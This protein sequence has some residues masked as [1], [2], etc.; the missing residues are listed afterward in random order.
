MDIIKAFNELVGD[1]IDDVDLNGEFMPV[2]ARNIL[3]PPVIV[4]ENGNKHEMSG[5]QLVT[6]TGEK[7][8]LPALKVTM[9][10]DL[11]PVIRDAAIDDLLALATM[12]D[13]KA[14]QMA[15]GELDAK[16]I[17]AQK[18][19]KPYLDRNEMPPA[20]ILQ[21]F[22]ARYF[23]V[24]D[25]VRANKKSKQKVA[26]S[27]ATIRQISTAARAYIGITAYSILSYWT[28][29]FL[30]SY[31]TLRAKNLPTREVLDG[32][33]DTVKALRARMV[34]TADGA[35]QYIVEP[36]ADEERLFLYGR[37]CPT[38]GVYPLLNRLHK[39]NAVEHA[40]TIDYLNW[41]ATA[42]VKPLYLCKTPK[43]TARHLI[44]ILSRGDDEGKSGEE[45]NG[46]KTDGTAKKSHRK[47]YSLDGEYEARQVPMSIELAVVNNIISNGK[48]GNKFNTTA[49]SLA[50]D[51]NSI[52]N[53]HK[54]IAT[55]SENEI[56][57]NQYIFSIENKNGTI[58]YVRV[59]NLKFLLRSGKAY[60]LFDFFLHEAL[61]QGIIAQCTNKTYECSKREVVIPFIN[62]INAGLANSNEEIFSCIQKAEHIL[63]NLDLFRETKNGDKV[64]DAYWDS[65][66]QALHYDG[67]NHRVTVTFG[68]LYI[69]YSMPVPTGYFKLTN[70]ARIVVY[71]VMRYLRTLLAHK[72]AIAPIKAETLAKY[73]KLP[74][75]A[76]NFKRDVIKPFRDIIDEINSFGK[77][78]QGLSLSQPTAT[79]KAEFLRERITPKL[80][81]TLLEMLDNVRNRR[82]Y[83]I[84]K[85]EKTQQKAKTMA[86]AAAYS[87]EKKTKKKT[88]KKAQNKKM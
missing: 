35:K 77:E 7:I 16:L 19:V 80:E 29:F 26:L 18:K 83:H 67:V 45:A 55:K 42:A 22:N 70:K 21:E 62:F 32:L 27:T 25:I 2:L 12:Q 59:S 51:L 40:Q 28:T 64:K 71:N 63:R 65:V 5:A 46:N 74:L 52:N 6:D 10:V 9:D 13:F 68:R 20:D 4:D 39:E 38:G 30:D 86:L 85:H 56:T 23:D 44:E 3:P 73:A 66:I 69:D 57:P 15:N 78:G 37:H 1:C 88:Q 48:P 61:R 50:R 17:A 75:D 11:P 81:G 14:A 84:E 47:K 33:T 76:P 31:E 8:D 72:E 24:M 87:K 36:P 58:S 60:S 34:G 82:E 41:A 54:V 49:E 53:S 79:N 43:A